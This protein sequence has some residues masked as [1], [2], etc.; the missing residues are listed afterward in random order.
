[1][2]KILIANRN[3]NAMHIKFLLSMNAWNGFASFMSCFAGISFKFAVLSG[4][5]IIKNAT[6]T[7]I[8]VPACTRN[9]SRT[10]D[11]PKKP[12]II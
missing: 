5:Q 7:A 1:M 4:S 6:A 8:R 2:I 3:I 11:S 9:A 12:P 10:E